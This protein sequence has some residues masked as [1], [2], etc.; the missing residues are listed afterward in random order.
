MNV[1]VEL[2]E[3]LNAHHKSYTH[4]DLCT[5]LHFCHFMAALT[6]SRHYSAG[7]IV[8]VIILVYKSRLLLQ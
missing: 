6:H 8:Q 3:N 2:P 5:L 7:D 4:R 1:C